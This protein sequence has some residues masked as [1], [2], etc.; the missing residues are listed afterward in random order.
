MKTDGLW[1]TILE[2]HKKPGWE[3]RITQPGGGEKAQNSKVACLAPNRPSHAALRL[4]VLAND[5]V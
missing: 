3:M 2:V 5:P 1:S 4:L